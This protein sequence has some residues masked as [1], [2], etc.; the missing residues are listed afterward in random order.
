VTL[1]IVALEDVDPKEAPAFGGKAAGLALLRRM[2]A[3]VPDAVLVT[4]TTRPPS[5][6]TDEER[7]RLRTVAAGLLRGG[8][9]AVRSSAV[10]EDSAQRSFAGLFET[11]LGVSDLE[12]VEAAAGRCIA[13]ATAERVR[14]YAGPV[15]TLPVGLV[16]QRQ[17]DAR[18]AG[19]CFTRDP[20]GRDRAI[21][22]EAV[23]GL[24]EG[25]VSGHARP[26]RWRVY[27]NGLGGFEPRCE[28]GAASVLGAAEAA[29][30]AREA[31]EL[32]ALFAHPVDLEWALEKGTG[33]L[34]WLQAR[35]ITAAAEPPEMS[36]ERGA[37]P[38]DD[39]PVTV[40]C[41]FNLRETMPDPFT[42]MNWCLW[43]DVVLPATGEDL[44]AVPRD[45]ELMR[46]HMG[47]DLVEG[48]LYW[49]LN[50]LIG[51]L[52]GRFLTL[53]AH[54]T[55][56]ALDPEAARVTEELLDAGILRP[57]RMA[58]GFGPGLRLAAAGARS[59]ARM[60]VAARPRRTLTILRD[61]GR[62]LRERPPLAELS[63]ADLL[64]EATLL[65]DPLCTRL[66]RS[67]HTMVF[68]FL[69]YVA[70]RRA[71]AA[72]PRAQALLT[73]G[74]VGPTTEISLGI[75]RLVEGARPLARDL[76]E[77]SS[78]ED[79]QRRLAGTAAGRAWLAALD[80]FLEENGQRCPREFEIAT[81][82]WVEDPTMILELVRAGLRS[83][84]PVGGAG[85]RL[86]R[87]RTD[88]ERALDQ[89]LAASPFWR[90]PLMRCLAHAVTRFMPLRE[91]PKH[92]AM[93]VFLRM[94][95]ALL[96]LGRRLAER[97]ALD[98]AEDVM[99]LDLAEVRA[100][101]AGEG[102]DPRRRIA[103][104]RSRWEAFRRL[105]PPHF[106][107]SD[108]VPVEAAPSARPDGRLV[109]VGVSRGTARGTVCVLREPDPSRL[110]DGDVLVVE[111][112][113]PGWT[114]LFPRAAAVVMEV[115]GTMCHAAVV[116]R[117]LGVPAVFGVVG[118]TTALRDGMWVAVD[119]DEGTVAP[120]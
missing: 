80:A 104:R 31:A 92:Y 1:R 58:S 64:D 35:P 46:R 49:N 3:A 41:N 106:V 107:R 38:G 119:G 30:V 17:V 112:A 88:R 14:A 120:A 51:G 89:A 69:A 22:I 85:E 110:R 18:A 61:A 78:I 56:H 50:A 96:E 44:F 118:A 76:L 99:F 66:R 108:G 81:P 62:L 67:M 36:V 74:I 9:V 101:L 91:A 73:A 70:A 27:R 94:R 113:D 59:I 103:F 43:R 4:P 24:A 102:G 83:G 6:W 65:A 114:P 23:A 34:F 25:L 111:F 7:S 68:A 45:S 116:A 52:M 55:L 47:I 109:G 12:G 75:D 105:R 8:A 63:D 53:G 39:G 28:D 19:V 29:A 84:S 100:A 72:H 98:R 5:E 90:R 10:G 13:S 42:P 11:V 33:R 87:A 48:R 21:L 40:W 95:L 60:L 71:F 115:G 82:R 15:A 16:V 54:G 32:E 2:G 97:S 37:P 26:E 77:T 117:E 86:A 79:L 20:A 93:H 57:R